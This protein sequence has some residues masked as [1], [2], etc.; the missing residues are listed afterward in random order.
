MARRHTRRKYSIS[1]SRVVSEAFTSLSFVG[2]ILWEFF[3]SMNLWDLGHDSMSAKDICDVINPYV[4]P[5]YLF[6]FVVSLILLFLGRW[7]QFLIQLPIIILHFRLF[8]R[9]RAHLDPLTIRRRDTWRPIFLRHCILTGYHLLGFIISFSTFVLA[10]LLFR[11]H[12]IHLYR[13]LIDLVR[14]LR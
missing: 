2:L 1:T 9:K 8:I 14:K 10:I 11:T 12:R 6:H 13:F 4:I 7:V 3:I 5:M